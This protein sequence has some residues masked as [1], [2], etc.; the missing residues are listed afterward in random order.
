HVFIVTHVEAAHR[1]CDV[2]HLSLAKVRERHIQ[3]V[4]HLISHGTRYANA[5]RFSE[6]FEPGGYVDA[7]A[8]QVISFGDDVAKVDAYAPCD[9]SIPRHSLVP[10]RRAP[11]NFN[12]AAY[13]LHGAGELDQ[14]S[15]TRGLDNPAAMASDHRIDD[16]ATMCF[17]RSK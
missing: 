9:A 16:L 6:T 14:N 2:L 8:I 4:A 10:L 1:P 5:T 11:L 3:P 15:V 12:R 7:V 17:E 13:G